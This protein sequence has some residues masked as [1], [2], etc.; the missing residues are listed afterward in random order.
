MKE[1]RLQV[2]RRSLNLKRKSKKKEE[3]EES[4]KDQKIF[5]ISDIILNHSTASLYRSLVK[6]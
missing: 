1:E 4:E 5:N 2:T 3:R 6:V